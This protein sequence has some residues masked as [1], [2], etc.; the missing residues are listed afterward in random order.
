MPRIGAAGVGQARSRTLAGFE[1]RVPAG[2]HWQVRVRQVWAA[3]RYI[4]TGIS[5]LLALM[6]GS[7]ASDDNLVNLKLELEIPSHRDC[8]VASES[9]KL[10]PDSWPGPDRLADSESDRKCD[11]PAVRAFG[12]AR[13]CKPYLRYLR[14]KPLALL[15]EFQVPSSNHGC[16]W[17]PS[18]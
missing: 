3:G 11:P 12:H 15:P 13:K 4:I 8:Q 18:L 17:R 14:A 1:N 7:L 6:L 9:F 16:Q 10:K 5:E 2:W